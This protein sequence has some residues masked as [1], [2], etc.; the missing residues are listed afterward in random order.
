M[1][2][3]VAALLGVLGPAAGLARQ[4]PG[5]VVVAQ[6]TLTDVRPAFLTADD[7]TLTLRGVVRN[8]SDAPLVDPLPTLRWSLDALQSVDEVD[9]V[10]ADP[11]FRYGRVDYTSATSLPTLEPGEQAPFTLTVP[12]PP[13]LPAPGV[14]VVG[15]DVLAT[16]PDGLRVFVAAART[17]V[18]YDVPARPELPVALLWPVATDPSLLPD[19]RLVDDAVA[20]QLAPGGRLDTLVSAP[21]TAPV[22]WVVDP[23]LL[24][25]TA[26][27]RDGYDTVDPP[28]PGTGAGAASRFDTTLATAL[29]PGSDVRRLPSADPDVGGLVSGGWDAAEVAELVTTSSAG[30]DGLGRAVPLLAL[31]A[32]R[33]VDS[34]TLD[35]YRTA[36]VPAAV[37]D[38]ADLLPGTTAASVRLADQPGL[39]VVPATRLQGRVD[40]L[41]PALALRQQV[42]AVTALAAGR[43]AGLTLAPSTRWQPSPAAAAAVL[44]AWQ[45][46]PWVRPVPLAQL[47]VS[48]QPSG[49]L[50]DQPAPRPIDPAITRGVDQLE[51]DLQRLAPLFATSPVSDADLGA[52]EARATSSAWVTDPD[53]GR[54]YV[55]ALQQGLSGAE[56]QVSLVLSEQITL[57]SRSG[58][59]PV[60]LVNDSPVDV[61]VGVE[62]TSQNSTRLRVEQAEP[63]LLTAGEKRTVSATALATANGRVVVTARLVTTQGQPVGTAATTV[64]DV[65]NVGALGW[66]VVAAGGV[67]LAAALARGRVRRRTDSPDVE[68]V[69]TADRVG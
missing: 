53:G 29:T 56:N 5:D 20:A 60:T 3:A 33:R 45:Q 64:V 50:P 58:R 49:L 69:P 54:A 36:G 35:A 27:M 59:F 23:D 38:E 57:S 46:A 41:R 62:F 10:T 4:V 48:A 19:G 11:L 52:A 47:P 55:E 18:A 24:S 44:Q 42:L 30:V 26:A 8:V 2:L 43:Q 14:Y 28:G 17:T 12:L 25:T 61:V 65:T 21:G 66:V 15:V 9:L 68:P 34:A 7:E 67:L 32:H 22:T 13:Q 51:Q 39:A 37:L 1:L 40:G 6:A 31:L 63:T 16:L